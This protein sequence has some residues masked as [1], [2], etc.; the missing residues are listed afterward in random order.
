ME[1]LSG[2]VDPVA[3]LFVTWGFRIVIAIIFICLFWLF[4]SMTKSREELEKEFTGD[5][6]EED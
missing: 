2:H 4:F 1:P 5:D 6:K 3:D